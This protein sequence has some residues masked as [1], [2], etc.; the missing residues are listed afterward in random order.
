M[1]ASLNLLILACRQ[2]PNSSNQAHCVAYYDSQWTAMRAQHVLYAHYSCWKCFS[3]LRRAISEIFLTEQELD[4]LLHPDKAVAQHQLAARQAA[5][6]AF[7]Q[8]N[9]AFKVFVCGC[10]RDLRW[11]MRRWQAA[12]GQANNFGVG[13]T[14]VMCA[15]QAE[16]QRLK[17]EAE[18]MAAQT[19]EAAAE[20]PPTPQ[21]RP[22][23]PEPSSALAHQQRSQSHQLLVGRRI[24]PAAACPALHERKHKYYKILDAGC[25]HTGEGGAASEGAAGRGQAHEPDDAVR[26]VR[27]RA[28]RTGVD[29]V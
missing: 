9:A 27:S 10:A 14:L 12:E 7:A 28:R 5:E 19:P 23:D 13:I 17:C 1:G 11:G 16:Q 2:N 26:Q 29:T 25:R 6:R 3:V 24:L 18:S 8:Q 4:R 20:V 21:T 22:A 15:G